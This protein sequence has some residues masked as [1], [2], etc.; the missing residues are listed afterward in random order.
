M[1]NKPRKLTGKQQAF[2]TEYVKGKRNGTKAALQAYET[3]DPTVASSIATENLNKPYIQQAIDNA[4][5]KAGAT[6]EF[7]V[8][9]LYEVALQSKELGAKRLASKDLLELHGWQRGDRPSQSLTINN[10]FFNARR[11]VD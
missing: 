1:N 10:A 5:L 6:P 8:N 11:T 7:A 2:V 4:L 9:Q 3:A